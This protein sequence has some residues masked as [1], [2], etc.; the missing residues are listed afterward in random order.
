M[1][2]RRIKARQRAAS[3]GCETPPDP[4]SRWSGTS[5]VSPGS[6][7]YAELEAIAGH[8]ERNEPTLTRRPLNSRHLFHF[9][10]NFTG[11]MADAKVL[12]VPTSLV[13]GDSPELDGA[14][15][16]ITSEAYRESLPKVRR[17]VDHARELCK[18]RG[19]KR[20]FAEPTKIV[21]TSTVDVQKDGSVAAALPVRDAI[22]QWIAQRPPRGVSVD[23]IRRVVNEVLGEEGE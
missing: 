3:R 12:D 7:E 2:I 19:V 8:G 4:K 13:L 23:A 1:A 9:H 5:W 17:V 15:V 11:D 22:D 20:V 16:K 18:A 6:D 14:F 10:L 21:P